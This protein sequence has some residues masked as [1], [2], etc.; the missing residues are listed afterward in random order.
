VGPIEPFEPELEA[1]YRRSQL[2]QQRTVIRVATAMTVL[3]ALVRM[4][5]QWLAHAID[6]LLLL[7][8]GVVIAASGALAWLAWSPAFD[9][10]YTRWATILVPLRAVIAAARFAIA[11]AH[12][13]S[14]VLM[15][16]PLMII[17][18]FFFLGLQ[19]RT[20]LITSVLATVTFTGTALLVHLPIALTLTC[21]GYLALVL[22][23][24]TTAGWQLDRRFRGAFI[25]ARNIVELARHDALTGTK[26]RR[27]FDEHLAQVWQTAAVEQRPIAVLLIDV[28]HFK[29]YNDSFGHI[30]GDKALQEVA[31]TVQSFAR[32]APDVVARYGGEEFAAVLYDTAPSQARGIAEQ[33][34]RAVASLA[35][36]RRDAGSGTAVTISI[37][38][39]AIHPQV[40][41]DSRGSVQLADEALYQAKQNGRNRV[42]LLDDAQYQSMVTGVF[43]NAAVRGGVSQH[44]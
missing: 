16:L 17:G 8:F 32:R 13:S 36:T 7:Q 44:G 18:P 38:V 21:L 40:D 12:G 43:R 2:Y 42:E 28:D 5:Q 25:E 29:G 4:G 10:H 33:M 30:A 11:A 24:C 26:N 1:Q 35:I 41:R 9:A 20:A 31:R 3:V 15:F 27:V 6:P 37:G 22:I 19:M 23:A 39:A 34:R 14:E